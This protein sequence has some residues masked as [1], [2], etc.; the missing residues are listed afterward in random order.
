MK[1]KSTKIKLLFILTLVISFTG[2]AQL[3]NPAIVGYWENWDGANFVK[4]KDIDSRYNVIHVSFASGKGTLDYD[5]EFNPPGSYDHSTFKNEIVA[6]QAEGKKVFISIGGQNDNVMLDDLFEKNKFVSSV[7]A[8]VDTWGFDG[9]DIDLE[10]ASLHFKD[11]KMKNSSDPRLNFMIDGIREIMANHYSTHGKKLLL[12][13][14]PETNYVQG[15]LSSWAVNNAYG[16]AYLPIIEELKDSID[17]LNVQLYNSGSQYGLD[18]KIYEQGSADFILAMTEV[19]I[20]GF[21]GTGNIGKYNGFPSS[22]TGVGLPGCHSSDAV[23]HAEIEKAMAY[24]RGLGPKPGSYTLQKAG[25]YPDIMGMM[26][27]S[28]NSD[29]KCSPSYGYIDTWSKIFTNAPYI[30]ISAPT[31][32]YEF[33]EKG[34]IIRVELS[35]DKFKNTLDTANWTLAKLP[36]GI[37]LDSL[38]RVNDST[39][40]VV[41]DG[42]SI[43]PY[44]FLIKNVSVSL[45]S[46]EFVTSTRTLTRNQGVLL[47]KRPTQ[48]PGKLESEYIIKD[49]NGVIHSMMGDAW[50][51]QDAHFLRLNKGDWGEFNIDVQV[52]GNYTVDWRFTTGNGTSGGF[53][54]NIDGKTEKTVSYSSSTKYTVW[55]LL[56]FEIHL[57]A[58]LHTLKMDSYNHW[59]ASDYMDFRLSNNINSV[60]SKNQI[61]YPNPTEK[62]IYFKEIFEG[63]IG[64]YGLNGQ[65]VQES[66][67]LNTNSY[68]VGN[69]NNGVYILKYTNTDGTV[70][71]NKLVKK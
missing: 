63:T 32:I 37:F 55:N 24:L 6:L 51:N 43:Y 26:T 54:V 34:A 52:D 59:L 71:Y 44:K 16:G 28:I 5:L 19:V 27:W 7:N 47:K 49:K 20:K 56:N 41:L 40:N 38:V 17:M 8:I 14:A 3:P 66:V 69:L 33:E 21:T 18:G 61:F 36:D 64:V 50:N 2:I 39:V 65:L 70:V 67:N 4:L 31:D 11:I 25:G 15:G 35:N 62:T 10:G 45:K 48:I 9:I 42:I 12:T 29:K 22:K 60:K 58:G 53:K 46:S 68:D 30:I 57:K 13:M 1:K 23:P